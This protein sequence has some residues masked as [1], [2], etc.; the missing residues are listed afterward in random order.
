MKKYDTDNIFKEN[1]KAEKNGPRLPKNQIMK[2]TVIVSLECQHAS[3]LNL[4]LN[5]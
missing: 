3:I 1:S 4:I 5:I 2:N